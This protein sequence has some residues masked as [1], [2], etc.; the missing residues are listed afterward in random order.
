[1]SLFN[2]FDSWRPR[3]T[4]EEDKPVSESASETAVVEKAQARA[5]FDAGL[6][7]YAAKDFTAAMDAFT[8]ALEHR[9]DYVEA[10]NNLGLSYIA[11]GRFEDAVD[12]FVLAIH[13]R[14]EFAQAH[15]NLALAELERRAFASAVRSLERAIEVAPAYAAAHNALG[16]VLTHQTGDFDRGA[17]H[18][19]EAL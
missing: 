10:H 8:Q 14:P 3:A 11:L 12:E 1:M 19:R 18:I 9:H 7:A 13:F 5:A 6:A 2:W 16:Y 15:Y 17:S 4:P